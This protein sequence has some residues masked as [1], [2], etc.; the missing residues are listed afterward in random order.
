VL[1]CTE[2]VVQKDFA[3][4][5]MTSGRTKGSLKKFSRLAIARHIYAPPLINY[6]ET[7]PLPQTS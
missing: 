2:I 4:P 5:N 1:L 7:G 6:H 3:P